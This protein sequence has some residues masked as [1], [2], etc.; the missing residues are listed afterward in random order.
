MERVDGV[1]FIGS[2]EMFDDSQIA[3]DNKTDQD[4]FS[5][6]QYFKQYHEEDFYVVSYTSHLKID[7]LIYFTRIFGNLFV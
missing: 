6:V 1:I 5:L 2:R 7:E 4:V 3:I